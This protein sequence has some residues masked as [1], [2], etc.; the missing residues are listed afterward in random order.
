MPAKHSLRTIALALIALALFSFAAA[1][2]HAQAALLMEEPYGFFGTI[3]PTGHMAVYFT[4]VCAESPVKLRRCQ[5]GESGSV[6]SRYQ[7][8]DGYDWVAMPLLPY[9]YSVKDA[10]DVPAHVDR[11]SVANLR[12]SY[13]EAHLMSLGDKLDAGNLVHGGWTQLVGSAYQRRIYAFR[14]ETSPEQDDAL[15]ARMNAHANKSHFDLLYNNCADFTR[16]V[17]NNYFPRTFRRSLF[18]DAGVTTPKQ[19]TYKLVRYA[20]KHPGVQL[21]V[22]EIPM[23]PGFEHL[24]RSNNGVAEAFFTTGYAIPLAMVNPYLAGGLFVDYLV[25]GRFHLVPKHPQLLAPDDM[26]ALTAPA[27]EPQNPLSAGTE[28]AGAAA[29]GFAD[30]QA[31]TPA[32]SGLREIKDTHE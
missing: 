32:N 24:R 12:N 18:P 6:I 14:F 29:G 9:L 10:D 17:L 3:N 27:R 5:P 4:R 19:I 11:A 31:G 15:I 2:G 22:F 1:A 16:E 20:R 30:T 7:G 26:L 28:A 21:E 13:H 23:I 25:R 8:I